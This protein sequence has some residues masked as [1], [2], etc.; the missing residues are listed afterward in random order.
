VRVLAVGAAPLLSQGR[1][2]AMVAGL[3]DKDAEQSRHG[4]GI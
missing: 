2:L 3:L 4:Y 1:V